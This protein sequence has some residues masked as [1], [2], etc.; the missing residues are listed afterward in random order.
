M[1][2]WLLAG[3]EGDTRL[4]AGLYTSLVGVGSLERGVALREG[5]LSRE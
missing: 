4:R 5:V 3:L 2:D 1:A